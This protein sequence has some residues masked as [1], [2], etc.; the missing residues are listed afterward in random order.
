MK[1]LLPLKTLDQYVKRPVEKYRGCL[2]VKLK[3]VQEI[4]ILEWQEGIKKV[5]MNNIQRSSP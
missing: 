1:K 4:Q 5:F 2:K 3:Q